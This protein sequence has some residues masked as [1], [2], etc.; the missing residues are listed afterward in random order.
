MNI[1]RHNYEEYFL[2]YID[3]E[4]DTGERKAVENFIKLNTDLA[5]ELDI[6]KEACLQPETEKIVFSAKQDLLQTAGENIGTT[7]YENY[8]LRYIDNELIQEEKH[9]VETY[10]LQHPALQAEFL[11][12]KQTILPADE[13]IF[14]EKHLLYRRNKPVAAFNM[15]FTRITAAAVL[16]FITGSIWWLNPIGKKILVP[17]KSI[18]IVKPVLNPK[19]TLQKPGTK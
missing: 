12:L 6:L 2:L 17:G 4:L 11:G 7:N 18:A 8:F 1:N 16:I 9:S 15:R 14:K 5:A 3:N 13:I 10:V 19:K